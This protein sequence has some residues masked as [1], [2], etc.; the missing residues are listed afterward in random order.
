M[1]LQHN[2]TVACVVF[3]NRVRGGAK[4][5]IVGRTFFVRVSIQRVTRIILRNIALHSTYY[6]Y[7]ASRMLHARGT[8][9]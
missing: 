9:R 3:L 7:I 5:A 4:R 6:A 8:R 1:W 2:L